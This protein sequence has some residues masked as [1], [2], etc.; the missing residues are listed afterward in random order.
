[1]NNNRWGNTKLTKELHGQ[2]TKNKHHIIKLGVAIIVIPGLTIL[3][4]TY[5]LR[6]YTPS[7]VSMIISVWATYLLISL[8]DGVVTRETQRAKTQIVKNTLDILVIKEDIKDLQLEVYK[9][10]KSNIRADNHR[11]AMARRGTVYPKG[12]TDVNR[13]KD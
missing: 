4:D 6:R 10:E 12:G 9:E 11:K 7:W 5:V 1:M 2:L 3:L 8:Y 13:T